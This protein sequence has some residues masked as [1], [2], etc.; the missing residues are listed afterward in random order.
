[1]RPLCCSRKISKDG[2]GFVGA[3]NIDFDNVR[4]QRL[5]PRRFGDHS[6]SKSIKYH[7]SLGDVEMTMS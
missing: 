2:I 4:E 5:H 6:D 3:A 7:G 1:M